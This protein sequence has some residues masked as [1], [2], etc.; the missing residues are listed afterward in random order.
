MR[1][2]ECTSIKPSRRLARHS[3]MLWQY[4]YSHFCEHLGQSLLIS[5]RAR[6]AIT[7][8][9][10]TASKSHCVAGWERERGR[11]RRD[12]MKRKAIL[13]T[14]GNHYGKWGSGLVVRDRYRH[15]MGGGGGSTQKR[16]PAQ[17]CRGLPTT[18]LHNTCSEGGGSFRV[19][20]SC[21]LRCPIGCYNP[22]DRANLI[23]R[24]HG[25]RNLQ[26]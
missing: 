26:N 19:E 3:A 8:C 10:F 20:I 18:P 14:S 7:P 13:E 2:A 1:P 12:I 6:P 15:G 25:K 11:Q 21:S 4:G 9:A 5:L 23:Y 24:G 17:L 22:T 16:S